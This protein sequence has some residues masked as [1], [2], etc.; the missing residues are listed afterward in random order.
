LACENRAALSLIS[1]AAPRCGEGMGLGDH[2]LAR[3]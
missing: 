1:L 3:A 2:S